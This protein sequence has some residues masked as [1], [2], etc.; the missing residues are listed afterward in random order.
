MGLTSLLL[1]EDNPFAKYVGENKNTIRGAF[2]G[3]GTG[4]NFS[5][6][7]GRAALGAYQGAPADDAY[8]TAQ[9]A[10]AERQAM[11][12]AAVEEMRK[13]N[14]QVADMVA[15]GM[16]P[17]AGWTQIMQA[18]QGG[19]AKPIEVNGQ[20]V[21]PNTFDVLGD[22]RTPEAP[23]QPNLPTGYIPDPN[24]PGGMMPAPGSPDDLKRQQ[25][26]LSQTAAQQR[27]DATTDNT[28]SAIERATQLVGPMTAGNVMG[29]AGIVPII[30]QGAA[31]LGAELDTIAAN[32]GFEA[33]QAMRDAS[34]T[35]GALGQVTER[36]L[37]L[38]QA[39]VSSLKQTQDPMRLQASLLR[40]AE[41]LE[42]LRQLR[43]QA[44]QQP[45]GLSPDIEQLVQK[46]GG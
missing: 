3:F 25:A 1:G 4:R 10:E 40:I 19:P 45:G 16:D 6:G 41:H 18:M 43:Q 32:L 35:G 36:E 44:G 5:E 33:L 39:T 21:D 11:I 38:L 27:A 13:Y 7:L 46:Y 14:P 23:D 34:P 37:A 17:Q 28:L 8:A 2:A 20:L 30:G 12:E 9:R 31:D 29:N 42:N 24:T 15:G 22:Y 26:Q